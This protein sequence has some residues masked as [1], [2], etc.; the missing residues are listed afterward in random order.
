MRI[1]IRTIGNEARAREE[2]DT[3]LLLNLGYLTPDVRELS[4]NRPF[5]RSFSHL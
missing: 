4:S 2:G 3:D 5:G 1:P